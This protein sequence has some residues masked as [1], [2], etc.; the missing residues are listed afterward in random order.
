[1]PAKKVT[2]FSIGEHYHSTD[3]H[4]LHKSECALCASEQEQGMEKVYHLQDG[5]GTTFA[6]SEKELSQKEA[7]ATLHVL[8]V[9]EL[10]RYPALSYAAAFE[11]MKRING[12]LFRAYTGTGATQR[13][14]ERRP[15]EGEVVVQHGV[16]R[17]HI[18]NSRVYHSDTF[19]L[20]LPEGIHVAFVPVEG[21][22][23]P[24]TQRPATI[25][26]DK[27]QWT[28]GLAEAWLTQ[29][30]LIASRWAE[31]F[32]EITADIYSGMPSGEP[33]VVSTAEGELPT[34]ALIGKLKK[35]AEHERLVSAEIKELAKLMNI[36]YAE[37]LE[38]I[39]AD[40]RH[41]GLPDEVVEKLRKFWGPPVT[42]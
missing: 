23:L 5:V 34:S 12:D 32:E 19:L 17:F 9:Q 31:S 29:K 10:A 6:F 4:Q 36:S 24:G 16:S 18:D 37:S 40:D 13:D 20:P 33:R 1:M 39:L 22:S 21:G 28:R 14:I 15:A 38:I 25:T 3:H 42:Q 8:T 27:I 30:G 35:I 26:F 2:E 41:Q 11:R 7:G